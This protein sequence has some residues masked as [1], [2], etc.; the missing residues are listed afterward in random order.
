[1]FDVCVCVCFCEMIFVGTG[2]F[3]PRA[4]GRPGVFG[5]NVRRRQVRQ[6]GVHQ[7]PRT[8][9]IHTLEVGRRDAVVSYHHTHG[10]IVAPPCGHLPQ[11]PLSFARFAFSGADACG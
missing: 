5:G 1:M 4:G 3:Q 10:A 6:G 7:I 2:Y 8:G 11:P 9:M